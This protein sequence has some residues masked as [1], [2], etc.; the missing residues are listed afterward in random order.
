MSV[1]ILSHQV[2]ELL[3]Q[4]SQQAPI[5]RS[6]PLLPPCLLAASEYLVFREEDTLHLYPLPQNILL[7]CLEFPS[8][9]LVAYQTPAH[10]SRPSSRVTFSDLPQVVWTALPLTPPSVL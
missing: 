4:W 3:I 9:L 8:C 5:L 6:L 1:M 10:P 2:R 7:H